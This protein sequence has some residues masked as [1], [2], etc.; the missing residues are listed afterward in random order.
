MVSIASCHESYSSTVSYQVSLSPSDMEVAV[1][2]IDSCVMLELSSFVI[3]VVVIVVL[4]GSSGLVELSRDML[5]G[6]VFFLIPSLWGLVGQMWILVSL[7]MLDPKNIFLLLA[8]SRTYCSVILDKVEPTKTFLFL[9]GLHTL[10]NRLMN[11][12]SPPV[13]AL[14]PDDWLRIISSLVVLSHRLKMSASMDF[15]SAICLSHS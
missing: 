1:A 12:R 6:S 2:L 9:E 7:D 10:C 15:L 11:S 5:H 8:G 14:Y 3:H 13:I 4:T